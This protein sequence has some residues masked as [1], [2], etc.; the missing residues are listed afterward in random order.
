L[1]G[2]TGFPGERGLQGDRGIQGPQGDVG[3]PGPPG[4]QGEPGPI[5]LTG[6]DGAGPSRGRARGP[7]TGSVFYHQD[8]MVSCGGS[9]WVALVEGATGRPGDSKDWQLFVK[10]G[11]D[12]KDGERGERGPI[13]PAGKDY[14]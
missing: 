9:G 3:P 11:R 12:G 7:W 14:A 10:K 6:K 2:E 4:P 1:R 8:D 5:G 13:G